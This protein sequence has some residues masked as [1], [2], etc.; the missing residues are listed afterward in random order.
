MN[1]SLELI[2]EKINQANCI[3]LTGHT[4]PDG[5]AIGACLGL[6]TA[7]TK[8]GKQVSV[9]L[10]EYHE[11]YHVI[12]NHHFVVKQAECQKPDLFIALD[13]GDEERLGKAGELFKQADVKINIDHH[14]S[15]TYFGEL[16]YVGANASSASEI[17]F[18]L[19]DGHYEMDDDVATALYAGICYDTGGFRHTSTSPKTMQIAGR[20]LEY[21]IAFTKIYN[22]FFDS[23]SFIEMKA[24]GKAIENAKLLFDDVVVFSKLSQEDMASCGASP[25]DLDAIVNYLKGVSPN[26]IACFLYEVAPNQVKCSFRSGKKY[27]VAKLT[28]AFGGGG[29]VK[30]AGCT[31]NCSMEDASETILTAI[32]KIL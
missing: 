23:R 20:L 28:M 18:D 12:P 5:D 7:L 25:K 15:N 14:I 4:N 32:E 31:L 27:D 26:K 24:L 17:I 8:S 3:V 22:L 6:A 11:K 2:R 29:H 19:I 13:C 10:E 9:I 30:A 16:N 21:D 1:D